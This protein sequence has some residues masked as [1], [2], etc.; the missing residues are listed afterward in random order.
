MHSGEPGERVT[1]STLWRF[2]VGPPLR[3]RDVAREQISPVEGLPALSLDA[4]TSVAYGPEAI[5]AV[6]AAAGAAALHLVLPITIAIVALL[7]ILVFSYRQVIDA[8][9]GGGGAYAVSRANLGRGASLVAGAA[10]VVDYT[11]TVA[12]SIAA[13]VASLTSAFP[14]LTSAT[15]PICLGILAVITVLNLRG[16]GDAARAFLLPTMLFIVGL[17]VIIAIG[18]VHPLALHTA[19]PG[20]SLLPAKALGAVS[21][22]LILKAFSAGCSALT[23]VE[24][25][26][27]GVPLFKKPRQARAKQTEL[28]LGGILGVMLLGLAVLAD[29]WHV[30][31]R[32][33]QTVLSQIIAYAIGRH[34]AYYVMSLTIT[35]VLALAANTSFGGLPVLAS[36]LARDNFLPHLF[37]LRDDRQVFGSG[38]WAL[39]IG[40]GVLLIAVGGS[41]LTLIPLFA[42]GVFTGFTLSQTGLVVHWRRT[43]PAGWRRRAAI[44]GIGALVTAAA[45][46]IFLVTK[47]TAGAWVVVVTVPALTMLFSRIHRYY[48]RAGQALGLGSIPGKPA[49]EPTVVVVAVAQ[50]SRLTQHAIA[51]ALSISRHVI[52][53]T[54]V[55]SQT[56]DSD[57]R[58]R[59]LQEQWTRWNPGPPLRVLSSEYASLAGPI[60]AFVDQLRQ[61]HR[62]QVVVLIPVAVPDRLRYRALHNHFDL[63][64]TAALRDRPDIITARVPMPL[65]LDDGPPE[66]HGQAAG[67]TS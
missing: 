20:R 57:A 39:A 33:G 9:P 51:E 49:T 25:I 31:P 6:L 52:A 65:H 43:R 62:E 5:I 27:N 35:I 16:L 36:L 34:W 64:L 7:S 19:Q 63:V 54:V 45:T 61:Q 22:L 48:Q 14:G 2:L 55:S 8:Y 21:V 40:S 15:V 66:A 32:S 26:A 18:L 4:I 1:A 42:I 56:G 24:A 30:G 29:R 44:N 23:G 58:A 46:V 53:V 37:S 38:I 13:G 3:A 28:L 17:L 10:L 11:L 41:T 60:V 50:V 67:T 59:E 47:F 12:V